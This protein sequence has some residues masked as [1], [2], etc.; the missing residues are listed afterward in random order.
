METDDP[1]SIAQLSERLELLDLS[2]TYQCPINALQFNICGP[3]EQFGASAAELR[4][5]VLIEYDWTGEVFLDPE[6]GGLGWQGMWSFLKAAPSASAVW[7]T[8]TYRAA[9]TLCSNCIFVCESN[10]RNK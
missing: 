10:V 5:K 8:V 7:E 1:R 6:K 9:C 3:C 4:R 2:R